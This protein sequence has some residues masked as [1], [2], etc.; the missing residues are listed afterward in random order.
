MLD[1]RLWI[2]VGPLIAVLLAL[3]LRPAYLTV[4]GLMA[5][6]GFFATFKINEKLYPDCLD[7][8]CPL[9]ENRL[10]VLSG[11]LFLLT[12]SLLVL[13]LAKHIFRRSRPGNSAE[14]Q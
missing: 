1:W 11:I 12:G 10:S 6:A 14:L 2:S 5:F 13:A 3:R 7:R 9:W 4:L 8:G